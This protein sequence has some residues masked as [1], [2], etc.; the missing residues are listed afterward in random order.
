VLTILQATNPG[1][2]HFVITHNANLLHNLFLQNSV[3]FAVMNKLQL[4]RILH[5]VRVSFS[6]VKTGLPAR[7][8]FELVSPVNHFGAQF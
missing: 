5:T 1:I 2:H 3:K 6:M 8:N 4:V 7:I